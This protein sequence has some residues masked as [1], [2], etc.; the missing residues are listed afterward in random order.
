MNT[1][2]E[3]PIGKALTSGLLAGLV[4]G[5]AMAVAMLVLAC[6]QVATP[7]TIIGD[8]LSFL[9]RWARFCRSWAALAVTIISRNSVSARQLRASFWLASLEAQSS[10]WSCGVSH[11]ATCP[12]GGSGCSCACR[13]S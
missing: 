8:R 3:M 11:G 12:V 10:A 1:H 7:L 2:N 4:A 6:L 13:L 9:F 5:I